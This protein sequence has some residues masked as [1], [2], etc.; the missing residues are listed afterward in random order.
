MEPARDL[1]SKECSSYLSTS[2]HFSLFRS[3]VGKTRLL[4]LCVCVTVYQGR[5]AEK[6]IHASISSR[7]HYC[8]T[9]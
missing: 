9:F 4:V 6:R 1:H 5:D 7:L 2:C 8:D 3:S